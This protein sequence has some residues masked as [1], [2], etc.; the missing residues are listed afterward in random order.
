MKT[1]TLAWLLVSDVLLLLLAWYRTFY[2][3]SCTWV[4]KNWFVVLLVCV[5]SASVRVSDLWQGVQAQAPPDRARPAAQRWE[6]FPL[7]ALPQDVQSLRLIF[8]AHE[9]PVQVLQAS[10][11]SPAAAAAALADDGSSC[12]GRHQWTGCTLQ[13]CW[14]HVFR[15]R[16]R[17]HLG[18]SLSLS[19]LTVLSP[20]S[21]SLSLSV[22]VCNVSSYCCC[23][24][25][26]TPLT[27]VWHCQWKYFHC[28][29]TSS[30][31]VCMWIWLLFVTAYN[32]WRE[33][34]L[35]L[36]FQEYA[37]G[38]FEMQKKFAIFVWRV[39]TYMQLLG[40]LYASKWHTNDVFLMQSGFLLAIECFTVHCCHPCLCIFHVVCVCCK[41]V[42]FLVHLYF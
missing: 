17:R 8:T 29:D 23:L 18:S 7:W 28:P 34:F 1:V 20:L 14:R 31:V 37:C 41:L 6:T 39:I 16:V 36:R 3:A 21:L 32:C 38:N 10:T 30:I 5:R 13:C 19:L 35:K 4:S 42:H 27:H 9:E 12:S 22:G 25:H 33:Y 40:S 24:L 11:S 2:L 26:C 15:C